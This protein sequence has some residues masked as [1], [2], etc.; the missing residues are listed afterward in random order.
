M[1]LRDAL[2]RSVVPRNERNRGKDDGSAGRRSRD[3]ARA[4]PEFND[5]TF[6]RAQRNVRR[7]EVCRLALVLDVSP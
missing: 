6:D 4:C 7:G 1:D 2:E 3:G 5:R